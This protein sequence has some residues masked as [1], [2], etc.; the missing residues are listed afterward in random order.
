MTEPSRQR[1]FGRRCRSR[2]STNAQEGSCHEVYF[3]D[4]RGN[5]C[6]GIHCGLR[7]EAR[8]PVSQLSYS[9]QRVHRFLRDAKSAGCSRAKDS[10]SFRTISK[11]VVVTNQSF[12]NEVRGRDQPSARRVPI[13]VPG[14][15]VQGW[16]S[17]Y[18]PKILLAKPAR[19][20]CCVGCPLLPDRCETTRGRTTAITPLA[21][22]GEI[23]AR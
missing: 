9:T 11:T 1:W 6:A 17:N 10:S 23:P 7:P 22:A 2:S 15:S 20:P 14:T 3:S 16:A 13:P 8:G 12:L 18:A 4:R 19:P 5:S 21:T